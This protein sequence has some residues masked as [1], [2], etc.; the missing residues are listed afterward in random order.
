MAAPLEKNIVESIMRWLKTVPGCYA[1]KRHG[2]RFAAG[3]PDI[4]GCIDGRRF[5]IEV[6]RPGR[7]ATK[8]QEE[9]LRR[10]RSAGA[11]AGVVTSRDEVEEL[12]GGILP[13]GDDQG[14]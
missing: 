4:T 3:R 11:I 1:E 5:E 13:R 7:K 9:M 6:K 10:W 8:L 2:S 14:V 12:L